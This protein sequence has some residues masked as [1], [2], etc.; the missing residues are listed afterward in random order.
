[1]GYDT[2]VTNAG[3]VIDLQGVARGDLTA[4]MAAWMPAQKKMVIRA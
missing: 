1:M 4:M 3:V 2:A